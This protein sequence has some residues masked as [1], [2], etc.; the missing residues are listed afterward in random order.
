MSV[1]VEASPA[2]EGGTES[3]PA[4]FWGSIAEDILDSTVRI[5][6]ER[7]WVGENV[8]GRKGSGTERWTAV[9]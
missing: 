9:V 6:R 5:R 7:A 1:S 8:M 4:V 3:S 2:R